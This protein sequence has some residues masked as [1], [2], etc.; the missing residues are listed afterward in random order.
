APE[1]TSLRRAFAVWFGRVFLP[2]RL[3]GVQLPPIDDLS[4]V[5]HMLADNLETWTDQWKRE[6]MEQGMEQGREAT[7][8]ILVRLALRRFGATTAEKTGPLLARITD[9]RQ[10]EALGDELLT[11][12]TGD[13][14]LQAV[15]NMCAENES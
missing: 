7:R 6:G 2:R 8:H 10:L 12:A 9:L 3:P 14:W 5:Y 13:D 4:E 11:S 15:R 1:Q